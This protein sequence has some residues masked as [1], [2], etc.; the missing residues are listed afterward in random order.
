MS[1]VDGRLEC[2]NDGTGRVTADVRGTD[3]A[4][5]ATASLNGQDPTPLGPGNNSY[6]LFG[7][8]PNG[9]KVQLWV[10]RESGRKEIGVLT[11][12][13]PQ[14][15]PTTEPPVTSTPPIVTPP[16]E[17]RIGTQVLVPPKDQP[18]L[19]ATGGTVQGAFAAGGLILAGALLI[20]AAFQPKRKTA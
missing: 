12:D 6:T 8:F 3:V 9:T 20:T 16:P 13:C 10:D 14:P 4:V 7:T 19:P 2:L 1:N 17:P 11:V 15:T 18:T 5:H